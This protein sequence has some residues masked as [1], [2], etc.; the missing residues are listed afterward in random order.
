MNH[1]FEQIPHTADVK[2]RIYGN[3]KQE[4]FAHALEGMFR[5]VQPVITQGEALTSREIK[6]Q[7]VD[8]V[9]LLVD[10]LSEALCLS[11]I[12]NEVYFQVILHALDSRRIAATIYGSPV[13]R[14]EGPEI[15]AVTYNELVIKKTDQGWQTE[16]VF[17]I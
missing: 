9:N 1:Y 16:I 10:F 12:Y 2:L 5:I 6:I 17:D 11:D 15:K 4:L 14:F 13:E 3:T 7:A 8:E